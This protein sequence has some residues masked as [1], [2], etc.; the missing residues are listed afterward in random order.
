MFWKYNK[1]YN[2]PS[3]TY[4]ILFEGVL[5]KKK[6]TQFWDKPNNPRPNN[7]VSGALLIQ[8]LHKVWSPTTYKFPLV[9]SYNIHLILQTGSAA[10][11]L[12]FWPANGCIKLPN[13]NGH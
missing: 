12:Q 11:C 2:I 7:P 6:I 9:A 8:S 3:A 5:F 13:R 10:P 4:L 1:D